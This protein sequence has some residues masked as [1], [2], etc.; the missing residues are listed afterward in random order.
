MDADAF[1]STAENFHKMFP[2]KEIWVTEWACQNYGGAS[3]QC[4]LSDIKAFLSKT[5]KYMNGQ[6]W[7]GKYAWFGPLTQF[8]GGFNTL[9]RLITSGGAM[10]DL[11]WEY[12]SN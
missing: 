7:I 12:L 1:I 9:N 2:G 11:G 3:G 4:S 8:P 10:T 5:Q 6:S